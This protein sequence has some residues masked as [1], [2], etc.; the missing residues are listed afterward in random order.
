MRHA[1]IISLVLALGCFDAASAGTTPDIKDTVDL[2]VR[3]CIAGGSI[4]ASGRDI[5]GEAD[6]SLRSLDVRGNVKGEYKIN[7]YNA[8]GLAEGINNA[9]TQ[10]A[11]GEADKVRECL[12]PVRE[13]VLNILLPDNSPQRLDTNTSGPSRSNSSA[14]LPAL[15]LVDEMASSERWA[16]GGQ[17][18]CYVPKQAYSLAVNGDSIIWRN[19]EGNLDIEGIAH[20]GG[21]EFDT[22]TLKSEHFGNKNERIGQTWTYEKISADRIKVTPGGKSSFLLVRCR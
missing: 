8:E 4:T 22:T 10:V 16:I 21:S 2:M 14:S 17:S 11:A 9:M 6:L 1:K 19:G 20:R 7:H 18:N 13:R 15:T 3:L 12:R 5:S